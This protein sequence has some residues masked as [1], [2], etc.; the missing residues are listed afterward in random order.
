MRSPGA[1]AGYGDRRRC[2]GRR[3]RGQRP[4]TDSPPPQRIPQ[5][6]VVSSESQ[7]RKRRPPSC[8]PSTL[9]RGIDY[10]EIKNIT[11]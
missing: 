2:G 8:L 1:G 3:L 5:G 4:E 9:G 10:I 6:W 7:E 11:K